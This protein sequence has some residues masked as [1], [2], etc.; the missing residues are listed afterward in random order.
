MIH[1][2]KNEYKKNYKK[3]K[4]MDIDKDWIDEYV[5]IYKHFEINQS[6]PFVNE[7]DMDWLIEEMKKKKEGKLS[8]EKEELFEYLDGFDFHVYDIIMKKRRE[9]DDGKISFEFKITKDNDEEEKMMII[10]KKKKN[11]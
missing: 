7:S 1:L 5:K 9:E 10:I 8:K 2:V 4:E 11:I 6:F 3:I